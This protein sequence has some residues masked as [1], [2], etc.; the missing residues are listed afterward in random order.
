MRNPAA[1]A[2]HMALAWNALT[3]QA[4][5]VSYASLT[6]GLTS[7]T[8]CAWV[9]MPF[10]FVVVLRLLVSI[11]LGFNTVAWRQF[12]WLLLAWTLAT[13]SALAPTIL[14]CILFHGIGIDPNCA[15]VQRQLL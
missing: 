10:M 9:I 6:L 3:G 14:S 7:A 4:Q 1:A 11:S 12:L 5:R 15:I 8:S 13:A 2:F